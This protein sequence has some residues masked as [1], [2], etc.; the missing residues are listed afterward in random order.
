MR[1]KVFMPKKSLLRQNCL[2]SLLFKS[3][4]SMIRKG[5]SYIH[6]VHHSI[7]INLDD[8]V[9]VNYQ[10]LGNILRPINKE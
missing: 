6:G 5:I 4:K 10:K 9:K 8:G 1:Q 3:R 2:I 7:E